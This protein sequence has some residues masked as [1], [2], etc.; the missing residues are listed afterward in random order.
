MQ[1]GLVLWSQTNQGEEAHTPTC[2]RLNLCFVPNEQDLKIAKKSAAV[3]ARSAPPTPPLSYQ[4]HLSQRG[5]I[6]ALGLGVPDPLLRPRGRDRP[7][8][9]ANWNVLATHRRLGSSFR[10][11][12]NRSADCWFHIT[13]GRKKKSIAARRARVYSVQADVNALQRTGWYLSFVILSGHIG[14]SCRMYL[15]GE[16]TPFVRSFQTMMR[17]ETS[18]SQNNV[19]LGRPGQVINATFSISP[20]YF[21]CFFLNVF[22]REKHILT[23][24]KHQRGLV[25]EKW[26]MWFT[27]T[28]LVLPEPH[29][30]DGWIFFLFFFF[31]SKGIA[32]KAL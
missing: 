32:G 31:F 21:S 4:I 15:N 30:S 18:T 17:F 28:L 19:S 11:I 24:G 29:N 26:L 9:L 13:Q 3:C 8:R 12:S 14:P 23:S 5:T 27:R 7:G 20:Q 22:D 16:L 1:L 6:C 25:M 2:N 10:A